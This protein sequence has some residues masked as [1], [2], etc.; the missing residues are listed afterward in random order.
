MNNYLKKDINLFAAVGRERG[1]GAIDFEKSLKKCLLVFAVVFAMVLFIALSVNVYRKSKIEKLNES[2]EA[3]QSDLQEIEQF[4]LEAESLQRDID[5]FNEAIANFNTTSRLT[6]EDIKNVAKCMPSGLV[7]TNFSYSGNTISM[8][9]TGSTE[10]MIA[11]F[12]NNLRNSV[13]INKNA[14]VESEYTKKNFKSVEYP[15]VSKNDNI[16]TGNITVTLNDII[17]ETTEAPV[18]TTTQA[19][20]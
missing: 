17:V 1:I 16:Y 13:T 19:A 14:T 18:E 3:L 9:V 6:T 20:Q 12:A 7:L 4:K 2:I 11:D 10:L 5:K 8:S 15:G